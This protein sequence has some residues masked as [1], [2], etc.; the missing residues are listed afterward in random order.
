MARRL[1]DRPTLGRVLLSRI[2]AIWEPGALAERRAHVGELLVL[3]EELGDPFVKVWAELYGFETAME[4]GEVDEADRLLAEAQR[5]ALEVERA[6]RWFAE[7]PRAGRALFAGNVE[8]A[9]KLARE[10]LEIGRATQ[11]LNE[12]RIIYGVQR[13]EIRV[14]QDRVDEVLPALIEAAGSGIP[15]SRAMLAQAYCELGRLGDAREVFDPLVAVLPDMPPDPNWIIAVT[16]AAAVCAALGDQAAAARL[17]PLLAPVCRPDRRERRHLARIDR[18]LPRRPGHDPRAF[19]RRRGSPRGRRGRSRTNRRSRVA[20][21]HPSGPSPPPPRAGCA[22]G[23]RRGPTGPGPGRCHRPGAG[24]G[25]PGAAGR[26]APV[27]GPGPGGTTTSGER[28]GVSWQLG[29]AVASGMPILILLSLGPVAAMAGPPSVAVWALAALIGLAMA[30]PFAELVGLFP[31]QAGGIAVVAANALRP[32]SR[33]LGVI[34]QWGYWLGWTLGLGI[35][36]ILA[37]D[38]L[39]QRLLPESSSWVAWL[40]AVAVLGLSVVVNHRGI[41]PG[42]WVQTALLACTAVVAVVLLVVPLLTGDVELARLVPFRPPGG[43]TSPQALVALAGAFF[44]A[45]WSAYGAEIAL[46][47]SSE[48]RRGFRDA[49]RALLVMAGVMVVVYSLVPVL[50]LAAVEPGSVAGGP[51][52][53]FE[54]LPGTG[55]WAGSVLVPVALVGAFFL[56][57]NTIAIGSSRTLWQMARN[58]EAWPVL[59]RLNRHGAPGNALL[60][61]LAF[62]T[63]VLGVSFL[64]NENR[65][66]VPVALLASANVGYFVC[67]ILALMATWMMR[68]SAPDLARPFRAP[69]GAVGLGVL[70]AGFN[71]VLLV[72]AGAAWGWRN[73][74]LGVVVLVAN[75]VLLTPRHGGAG[76][77]VEIDVRSADATRSD[78][79]LD[80]SG[81]AG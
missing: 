44:I 25:Q 10:A 36:G 14:E 54:S 40:I 76:R 80:R 2:A 72:G 18:P 55:T 74:S 1:G 31:G 53:L 71:T 37:G 60:F 27:T 57:L 59:G 50:A 9:D 39:R 68:R 49:V 75:V 42:A 47:Y 41:R 64:I 16:R 34:V 32:H 11:P 29:M 8:E 23:R 3:A 73:I 63:T 6:L 67:I 30:A 61:D 35:N 20:G 48:Y 45:G 77:P 21:P 28:R 15:E 69:R 19:R 70:I 65:A 46:T 56:T 24:S 38:Y 66:E 5:T 12:F 4:V 13:F 62:N 43:W 79:K 33:F 58:G 78:P 51:V 7:F 52:Q 81:V 22:G 17:Y 26:R